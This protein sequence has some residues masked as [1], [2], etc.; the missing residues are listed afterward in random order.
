MLPVRLDPATPGSP[1]RHTTTEPLC[2]P[3]KSLLYEKT[4]VSLYFRRPKVLLKSKLNQI[5]ICLASVNKRITFHVHF[6]KSIIIYFYIF[7]PPLYIMFSHCPWVRPCV[8]L[9]VMFCFLNIL[10]SHHGIFIKPCKHVHICKTTTL[11]KKIRARGQF[12]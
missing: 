7:I 3:N 8:R 2:P 10:K 4:I 6:N 9:S 12:Y 1:V 5:D 11:N